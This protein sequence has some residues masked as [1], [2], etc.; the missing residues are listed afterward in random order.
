MMVYVHSKLLIVDDRVMIIGSANINDRS[1]LGDR[2]S[3]ICL[4]IE[5]P[6]GCGTWEIEDFRRRLWA[7]HL[8]VED[9]D[10]N[11][12]QEQADTDARAGAEQPA[13]SSCS[14]ADAEANPEGVHPIAG[15][16]AGDK[17][18][19]LNLRDGA[20]MLVYKH[21]WQNTARINTQA[22]QAAFPDTVHSSHRSF[23]SLRI[24]RGIKGNHAALNKVPGF[25]VEY[26]LDFLAA[27]NMLPGYKEK[28]SLAPGHSL[29]T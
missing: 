13:L 21:A 8:G 28:E 25:V 10:G 22:Y 15:S 16:G 29:F 3:E 24:A 20:S 18:K 23:Q 4:R 2:D 6:E 1:M 19:K 27:E 11:E 9:C 12:E 14:E 7:S 26:P 17:L 5:E